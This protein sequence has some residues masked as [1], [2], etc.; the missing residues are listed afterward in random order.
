[1]P[2]RYFAAR[3][4]IVIIARSC[5]Y[6]PDKSTA[7]T[8]GMGD[9][10][11]RLA[12]A[13]KEKTVVEGFLAGLEDLRS[14]GEIDDE[15]YLGVRKDYHQ[16]LVAA[17]SEI[18][19]LKN[20]LK[21]QLAARERSLDLARKKLGIL[22]VKRK[23]GEIS[24]SQYQAAEREAWR[25]INGLEKEV[26][27]LSSLVD[28]NSA[29]DILRT[30]KSL[31][32]RAEERTVPEQVAPP[33]SGAADEKPAARMLR[34]PLSR[35]RLLVMV[36]GVVVVVIAVV[37]GVSLANRTGDLGETPLTN[38]GTV[39]S[40]TFDLPVNVMGADG[41]GS[42]QFELVYDSDFLTPVDVVKDSLPEDAIFEY[43]L[44]VPDRVLVGVVH[45]NGI[46]GDMSV[47][48]VTFEPKGEIDQG[49]AIY[50]E[51]VVAYDASSMTSV[52]AIA[53]E[54]NYTGEGVLRAPT[55]SFT[56]SAS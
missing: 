43:R 2:A 5:A 48:R 38:E 37:V 54:G 36:G 42:L 16:R 6:D 50:V 51:N 33:T 45:A 24:E 41:I 29:S 22:D 3:C 23:V 53:V 44:D 39:A 47:V 34:W 21:E 18:A 31:P 20:E 19:H 28:A 10:V 35:G 46:S 32:H 15:H 13:F 52:E 8:T 9:I 4:A 11:E 27:A 56:S 25:E 49:T 55:I 14:Q 1:M 30:E 17:A 12:E 40:A 7:E 26:E